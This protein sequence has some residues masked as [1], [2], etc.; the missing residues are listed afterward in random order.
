MIIQPP[1]RV[2]NEENKNVVHIRSP[3]QDGSRLFAADSLG[4][5]GQLPILSEG[6]SI[7]YN[8]KMAH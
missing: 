8:E 2:N 7:E 3:L 6:V 4:V 5:V 1:N